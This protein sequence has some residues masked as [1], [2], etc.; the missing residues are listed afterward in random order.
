M[1]WWRIRTHFQDWARY[2]CTLI[3]AILTIVAV[4]LAWWNLSSRISE[5]EIQYRPFLNI[6]IDKFSFLRLPTDLHALMNVSLSNEGKVPASNIKFTWV[7]WDTVEER[8]TPEEFFFG[9]PTI[10]TL[11]PGSD[12]VLPGYS[13]A[14]ATNADDTIC[15][16]SRLKGG[17]YQEP[18]ADKAFTIDILATY[19]G[20]IKGKLYWFRVKY[21]ALCGVKPNGEMWFYLH[22]LA[23]DWD[24]GQDNP[25]PEIKTPISS[26]RT[27]N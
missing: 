2:Y 4:L 27:K 25:P 20:V 24:E 3:T 12:T 13:P 10:Y 16:Y 15:E 23:Q 5:L 17:V 8:T 21:I 1:N 11:P 7:I 9:R 26:S 19:T 22:P 6:K 18:E 14:V